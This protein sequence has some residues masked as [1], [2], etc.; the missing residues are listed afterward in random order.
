VRLHLRIG[1]YCLDALTSQSGGANHPGADFAGLIAV[2][3]DHGVALAACD[4]VAVARK[5]TGK[6]IANPAA[7]EP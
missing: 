1:R 7:I 2:V 6:A 5:A 4:Q 3:V